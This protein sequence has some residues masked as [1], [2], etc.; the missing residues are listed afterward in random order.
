MKDKKRI[1]K[2]LK[3]V[4]KHLVKMP[5][6]KLVCCHDS[7][8]TKYYQSDGKQKKY[9]PKKTENLRRNWQLKNI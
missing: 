7:K 9:I 6:G 3:I 5:K 1:E 4:E 2:K 8:H